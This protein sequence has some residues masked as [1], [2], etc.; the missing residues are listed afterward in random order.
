MNVIDHLKSTKN[1]DYLTNDLGIVVRHHDT[2]PLMIL[3]YSMIDSP[4][5]DPLVQDCRGLVLDDNFDL[6]A[7]AFPRFFNWGEVQD[8]QFNFNQFCTHEKVDGSLILLYHFD[9]NWY[10]N[11]RGSFGNLFVQGFNLTWQQLVLKALGLDSF[12][13][14]LDKNCTYVCELV[15][16]YNKVVRTYSKPELYL[17]AQFCGEQEV[18]VEQNDL[19]SYPLGYEFESIDEII[20]FLRNQS[21]SDPT[22]EGVVIKD[23][24]HRRYKVKSPTYLAFHRLKNNGNAFLP[25][26]L[27][28]FV[29]AG[30]KDELF[31]YFPEVIDDY[32]HCESLVNSAYAELEAL[33]ERTWQEPDQK[34]FA[35]SIVGKTPFTGLLFNLRKNKEQSKEL[36]RKLWRENSELIY[37]VLYQ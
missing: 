5:Y 27:I 15:S 29:L 13:L 26:N 33:W 19:F 7:R 10:A 28:E 36:L 9:G 25:K 32:N 6:V 24:L 17:L 21:E 4:K 16:P 14:N 35:L 18:K 12:N 3:N 34:T 20:D 11:T 23:D 22:A 37:K 2:L 30:E 1:L 31:T 8:P